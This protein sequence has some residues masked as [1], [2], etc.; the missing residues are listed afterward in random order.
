MA[1]HW[2]SRSRVSENRVA[3]SGKVGFV[4]EFGRG[5]NEAKNAR[6]C[7]VGRRE[8]KAVKT[9]R[10]SLF[11]KRIDSSETAARRPLVCKD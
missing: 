3:F 6:F 11:E 8:T 4:R 5:Q 7:V 1:S 2:Q 10:L 9:V